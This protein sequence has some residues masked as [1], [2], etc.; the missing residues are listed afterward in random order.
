[1]SGWSRA[2]RLRIGPV[3]LGLLLLGLFF[4]WSE[5]STAGSR[6]DETGRPPAHLTVTL[7]DFRI[8]SLPGH[9][10]LGMTGV[11]RVGAAKSQPTMSEARSAPAPP[12]GS[13]QPAAG[14][15]KLTPVVNRLGPLTDVASPPGDA[16]HVM[17]VQQDGLV[18][19]VKHGTL[20][21]RPFLDLRPVVNDDGEKGLLSIA[22]ARDYATSGLLYAFYNDLNGDIRVEEFH[23][24]AVDPDVASPKGRLLLR[25][26]KSN[27]NHNGGM[28]QVGPDRYLYIAVGDGGADPPAIPVGATGQT[29]DDLFGSILR[30]DPRHGDPY[31]IPRDNPFVGEA[32]V[33]PEIVAYGLRNPWRFWIDPQSNTMLIGDVGES[34]FEEIDRLPLGKL[35]LNYGWPCK[36]GTST[37]DVLI[38]TACAGAKITPPLY[39]YRHSS[40]RC[41]ITGGVIS[42]DPRLPALGGLYLWSDLC[43]GRIYAINPAAR[44]VTERPLGLRVQQP[45][46]LGTDGLGR[47]YI[48]SY[49]GSV[50]RLDP[51]SKGARS[52]NPLRKPHQ[53]T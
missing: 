21:Q 9:R 3:A 30:I 6:A 32:G 17:V 35:G 15:A 37:P 28:M 23:R 29:L 4:A 45:T 16:A 5:G 43:D 10:A 44:T 11:L 42:R 48:T 34:T 41:A 52:P 2:R 33:R 1:M 26:I 46:S 14:I 50:Y 51:P 18:R 22:F 38:P 31:A 40:R 49:K 8:R 13:T 12:A 20:Q 27:A 53:D 19:V 24:S 36:E 7:L 47:I 39:E 25:I